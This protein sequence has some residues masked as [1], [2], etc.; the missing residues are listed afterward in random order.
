MDLVDDE[1]KIIVD[2]LICGSGEY[3]ESWEKVGK[4]SWTNYFRGRSISKFYG[5]TSSLAYG[6]AAHP[7]MQL[8]Y[9]IKQSETSYM[10]GLSELNFNGDFTWAAQEEG[11]ANAISALNGDTSVNV[12]DM[13]VEWLEDA[14]LQEEYPEVGEFVRTRQAKMFLGDVFTGDFLN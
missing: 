12:K 6:M 7:D 4:T 2:V 13:F 10:G 8:R 9:V 11:R 3:P 5:N 1:S 14:D